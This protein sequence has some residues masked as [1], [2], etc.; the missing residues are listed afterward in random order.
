MPLLAVALGA[1]DAFARGISRSMSVA[2]M[3][4]DKG[5]RWQPALS[6]LSGLAGQI[7][8]RGPDEGDLTSGDGQVPDK[9]E[10]RSWC[11][12]S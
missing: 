11:R 3:L 7:R 12:V 2:L 6:G 1:L 5:R 4:A 10:P 9:A 8:H